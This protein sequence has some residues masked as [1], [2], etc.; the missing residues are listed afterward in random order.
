MLD[1]RGFVPVK[2]VFSTSSRPTLMSIQS[3]T[4]WVFGSLSERV[5]RSRLEAD[6]LYLFSAEV[7][8]C[9]TNYNSTPPYVFMA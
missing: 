9:G 1:S 3:S 7:K 6:N 5:K 8:K 4:Q 2:R